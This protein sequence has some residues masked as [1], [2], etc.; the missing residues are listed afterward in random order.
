LGF[1]IWEYRIFNNL[2]KIMSKNLKV[3]GIGVLLIGLAV[4][5]WFLYTVSQSQ[6]G[7][8]LTQG[9]EDGQNVERENMSVENKGEERIMGSKTEEN[10]GEVEEL[11]IEDINTSNWKTYRNEE[12]GFEIKYPEKIKTEESYSYMVDAENI[13]FTM[14]NNDKKQSFFSVE[15][16]SRI[17]NEKYEKYSKLINFLNSEHDINYK[18][19]YFINKKNILMYQV[20]FLG[21]YDVDGLVFDCNHSIITILLKDVIY[22]KD[23]EFRNI[24]DN[25]INSFSCLK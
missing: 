1:G 7:V 10:K 21:N 22:D 2:N 3:L 8:K 20:T 15:W 9:S 12:Y 23:K 25:I 6:N 16:G 17:L 11:Q 5:G 13:V 4:V 18:K 24:Y 14:Y 19:R